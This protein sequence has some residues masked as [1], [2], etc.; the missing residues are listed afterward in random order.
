MSGSS[1]YAHPTLGGSYSRQGSTFRPSP[2]SNVGHVLA[3][4]LSG[5][6]R[7]PPSHLTV[8]S[9]VGGSSVKLTSL[10]SASILCLFLCFPMGAEEAS[11]PDDPQGAFFDV[12]NINVVNLEV[13]VT[14]K[15]GNPVTNLKPGDFQVFEN[16]HPMEI[17]NFFAVV[18]GKSRDPLPVAELPEDQIDRRVDLPI[19][20]QRPDQQ[21]NLIIYIDNF[22]L[23]PANRNRVINRM[24]RFVREKLRP[25]DRV[26]VVSHD[27]S[28]HVRQPFTQ[29]K[30]LV[31]S[32]LLD[33]AEL[34]GNAVNRDAERLSV[35]EDIE[36]IDDVFSA[37]QY[38][39][40]YA[41]SVFTEMEFTLRNLERQIDA[42]SGLQGRKAML[43]V[44]D[45]IPL[46]V[47]EDVFIAVDE[48][49]NNSSARLDAMSYSYSNR[50][51]D[52][53]A[54]AN[55]GGIT[56]FT[57]DAGG[58][59][60][61]A[62]ISAEYGGTASGGSLVFIDSVRS[63]N[64]QEPLHMIADD[65]GGDAFVN[66]N[67]VLK[68]LGRMDDSFRNYYSLGYQAPH[69]G[70]GRYYKVEVK[71]TRKDLDVR[72]RN[73]YR[74]KTPEARLTDGSIAT[75]FFGGERNILEAEMQ[76]GQ[77]SRQGKNILL[78]VEI[79]IPIGK[80]A[81][82][83]RSDS[84]FGRVKVAVVVMDGEGS[85]SPVQQQE[86]LNIKI[87][88]QEFEGAKDKHYSYAVTLAVRPGV[89]RLAVGVRDEFA[90]QTSFL[91]RSVRVG[92]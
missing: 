91:R 89:L 45:G 51:H 25:E 48:F 71:T 49:Y 22:N 88:A 33:V 40:S 63:A 81:L 78:P 28:L 53:V 83:P 42:L 34:S 79:K 82:A 3:S 41:D 68:S 27:R 7:A 24:T 13:F 47:A 32:A 2:S 58:L 30:S 67:A 64:L 14:D 12:T 21:L 6:L 66:T 62:S 20:A 1:P 29:D 54:R 19:S 15:D 38:A 77:Y 86:P 26:M 50:Y 18:D 23:R 31:T 46:V 75:L 70:D 57:L 72:H 5:V 39:R 74:D 16:G 9:P 10:T 43:Y 85:V 80:L 36:Q 84:Y 92:G 76:F 52:I 11:T 61:H 87:P 73:G 69:N 17:T 56:F 59:Q 8:R 35:L 65:T 90:N 55:A 44:S 60:S 37:T 4:S